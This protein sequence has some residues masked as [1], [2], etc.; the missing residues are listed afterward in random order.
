MKGEGVVFQ[1]FLSVTFVFLAAGCAIFPPAAFAQAAT[2]S[3]N[4]DLS[5]Q[6]AFAA[7]RLSWAPASVTPPGGSGSSGSAGSLTWTPLAQTA[8]GTAGQFSNTPIG[9]LAFGALGVGPFSTIGRIFA[10]GGGN[11]FAGT[12]QGSNLNL[13][14]TYT[15]NPDCTL[16]ITLRDAAASTSALA[17]TGVRF[18]GVLQAGGNSVVAVQT[19]GAAF[20]KLEMERPALGS[21]CTLLSL[22]GGF[23]LSAFG[24]N[25]GDPPPSETGARTVS[26]FG[27]I[28][29]IFADGNGALIQDNA[30]NN[31][32][33]GM[34]QFVGS[35]TMNSDCTGTMTFTGTS[36]NSGAPGIPGTPTPGATGPTL[37]F[38]LTQGRAT[39]QT[40]QTPNGTQRPELLFVF[41]DDDRFAAV[42]SGR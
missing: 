5:G 33:L 36:D 8:P 11:L 12:N 27:F 13:T 17:N 29:R 14:G 35:Y 31:S 4:Q 7:S 1:R 38:V 22:A 42:G 34:R 32:P 3:G 2:C 9:R 18:E 23:G 28:G 15:V 10:D 6:F 20:T 21:G 24:L 19:N 16:T 30:G 26:P 39:N 41:N 40:G 25:L 37:S